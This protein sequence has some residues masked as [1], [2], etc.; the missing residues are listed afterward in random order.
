MLNYI[1]AQ[2]LILQR[3]QLETLR[4]LILASPHQEVCGL[5]IGVGG[6]V[7][8]LQPIQNTAEYPEKE[9]VM[10]PVHLV[11]SL[12]RI[13]NS[14]RQ[15]VAI[16]HSHPFDVIV[17]PSN[18]DLAGM[19]YPQALYVIAGLSLDLE[20]IVRAYTMNSGQFIEVPVIISN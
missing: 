10:S 3:S 12:L 5:M 13:E 17:C 9:F 14:S 4:T 19:T 1:P 16:Y 2:E 8:E 6:E 15:L 7:E 20:P 18:H 11:E